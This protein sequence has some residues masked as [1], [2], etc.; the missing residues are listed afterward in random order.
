[1]WLASM[2][3]AR[4]I[5]ATSSTTVEPA[6]MDAPFEPTVPLVTVALNLSPTRRLAVQTLPFVDMPTREPVPMMPGAGA[7]AGA[8]AGVGAVATG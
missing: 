1:M 7:V 3:S 2:G 6:G 4:S 8:G 5:D